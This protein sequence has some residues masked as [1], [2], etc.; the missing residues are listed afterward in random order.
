[1][2]NIL[3]ESGVPIKLDRLLNVCLN[4]TYIKVNIGLRVFLSKIV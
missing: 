3:I 2:Y 4:E 1:L